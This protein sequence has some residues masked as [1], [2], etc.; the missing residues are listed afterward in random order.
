MK[1]RNLDQLADLSK[2]IRKKHKISQA[3]LAA[4]SGAS[5]RM[6]REFESHRRASISMDKL[7]RMLSMLGIAVRVG[8]GSLKNASE[9]LRN[10]RL[11]LG[12]LQGDAARLLNIKVSTYNRMEN[13][14]NTAADKLFK[15]CRGLGL[16]W[17]I[18]G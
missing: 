18:E 8:G 15:A 7:T 2:E 13:G 17:E 1:I 4:F 3:S 5:E 10:R 14:G 9:T 6:V 16:P 11:E 12:Y